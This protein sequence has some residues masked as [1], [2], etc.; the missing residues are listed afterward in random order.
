MFAIFWKLINKPFITNI[1]CFSS[2][3]NSQNIRIIKLISKSQ[4]EGI[5]RIVSKTFGKI[6]SVS[7]I[8]INHIHVHGLNTILSLRAIHNW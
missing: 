4:I 2:I 6:K 5:N 8:K 7:L 1:D 3:K